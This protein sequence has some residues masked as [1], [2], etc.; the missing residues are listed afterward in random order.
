MSMFV[1]AMNTGRF[2]GVLFWELRLQD[3]LARFA[4]RAGSA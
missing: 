3:L 1:S 2:R 4:Y